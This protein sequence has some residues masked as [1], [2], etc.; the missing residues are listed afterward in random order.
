MVCNRHFL[1]LLLPPAALLWPPWHHQ[2]QNIFSRITGESRVSVVINPTFCVLFPS[3]CPQSHNDSISKLENCVGKT[4]AIKIRQILLQD[5]SC[6]EALLSSGSLVFCKI[7]FCSL[8]QNSLPL[9]FLGLV[10]LII[11][12]LVFHIME[13]RYTSTW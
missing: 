2:P 11:S 9:F 8:K 7:I 4:L 3:Q 10:Y 6:P 13:L 1:S 5:R 12:V